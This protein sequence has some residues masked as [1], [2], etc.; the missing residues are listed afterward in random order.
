M[1]TRVAVFGAGSWGTA[2]AIQLARN[3]IQVNLW[4]HEAGHIEKLARQREN[5]AYLPGIELDS[6]IHPVS[7]METCLQ[8]AQIILIAIPSK[9]FRG[10][11]QLLKPVLAPHISI[12]WASKGF[13]IET[14]KLMHELVTEELPG[15]Q[16]RHLP[17]RWP[18]ACLQPSPALVMMKHQPHF[19]PICYTEAV[20]VVTPPVTSSALSLA[21]R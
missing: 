2:L 4:G 1:Q 3:D 14:G 13:E 18:T 17:V 5:K 19:L 16:A 12:F 21:A 7:S 11:L 10:L 6:K 15:H 9:A 8:D 20:F